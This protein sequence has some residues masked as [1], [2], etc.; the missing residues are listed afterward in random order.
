MV[1]IDKSGFIQASMSKIQGL[2]KTVL[3]I[4]VL[5]KPVRTLLIVTEHGSYRQIYV[6]FKNFS[7]PVR[8]CGCSVVS[9]LASG[10]RDPRFDSRSR[11]GKF[12]CP[13][14][15]FLVS[16]AGTTLDKFTIL[17][18]KTLTGCP[19]CRESHPLCR[20]KNPMVI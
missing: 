20:L 18:I 12:W 17:W 19:L 16:F 10:A 11:Q 14:T 3:Y 7:K 9:S 6:K 4:Q 2:F 1:H 15:L 8:K 13:N 5:F